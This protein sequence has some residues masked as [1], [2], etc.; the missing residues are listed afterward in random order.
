MRLERTKLPQRKLGWI[1]V[2]IGTSVVKIAQV[3]RNKQGWRVAASAVIPRQKI[4]PTEQVVGDKT[5]ST[6]NEL[7]AAQS[8]Q[9]GYRGRKVAATL[10]MS[11]CDVHRLDR[12]L[13]Q[14]ANASQI[15]RQAIE[16]ATQ[17]SVDELQCDYWSA[18]ATDSKP[19]WS[20]ALTVPRSWTDQL[21]EDIALAGWNCEAIDGLPL[22]LTRA[23][24][25]VSLEDSTTPLAALDW[26]SGRATLCFIEN[27]QPAYVRCLKDCGL[28]NM[29]NALVES[30]QVTEL[31]AQRLLEEY[32]IS[33]PEIKESNDFAHLV[34]E[35]ISESLKQLTEE[36]K[37]SFSHYQYVRRTHGP[38]HLYLFG[39]GGMIKNLRSHLSTRLDLET[40]LWQLPSSS[41]S[42]VSC[43]LR[44]DC[45]LAQA[46]AL[47]ALA[48]EAS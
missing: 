48:W 42:L 41:Q 30:L 19:A 40:H 24:R 44:A 18:P 46:I 16:T 8:L 21:C 38:Q 39:G 34:Q 14:E 29:L 31:E 20:Q 12:D 13:E 17:Q 23:V 6:L 37:R 15:L 27:G 26:G 22:A 4:W 33:S 11:L 10:P 2:D 47:S 9:Q 43:D 36:I 32:G 28:R 5:S 45:L 25:M 1:G 3:T 35:I 7:Q